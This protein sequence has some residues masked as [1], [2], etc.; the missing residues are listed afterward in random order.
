MNKIFQTVAKATPVMM[1]LALFCSNPVKD[2]A[3][4]TSIDLP[5]TANKKFILAAMM[6]TLFFNKQQ[7][8]T[9]TTYDTIKVPGSR[10]VSRRS[11]TPL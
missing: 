6:D 2:V 9:T 3:W 7:V 8:L 5:I 10:T 1:V 4:R 11:S